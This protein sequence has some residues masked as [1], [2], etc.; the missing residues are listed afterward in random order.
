[1][2]ICTSKPLRGLIRCS[3]WLCGYLE[4]CLPWG[5]CYTEAT[6]H[7][8]GDPGPLSKQEGGFLGPLKDRSETLEEV[9]SANRTYRKTFG[10]SKY[11]MTSSAPSRGNFPP[12]RG[13]R[14]SAQRRACWMLVWRQTSCQRFPHFL[15]WLTSNLSTFSML[16]ILYD[17]RI[18]FLMET[19]S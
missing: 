19:S 18:S 11:T 7:L 14:N 1:M 3:R 16:I 5:L 2:R 10:K 13:L 4:R 6:L 8:L 9:G 12:P 15:L 17:H